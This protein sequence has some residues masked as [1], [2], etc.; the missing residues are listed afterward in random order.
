MVE[1]FLVGDDLVIQKTRIIRLSNFMEMLTLL[2]MLFGEGLANR[3]VA[4]T[5]LTIGHLSDAKT[6]P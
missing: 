1:E 3:T 5:R 2:I 6:S 4:T